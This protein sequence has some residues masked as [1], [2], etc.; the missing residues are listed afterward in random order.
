MG[1]QPV[2]SA[3]RMQPHAAMLH[4]AAAMLHGVTAQSSKDWAVAPKMGATAQ[5]SEQA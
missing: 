1:L 4:G 2:R 5:S 3:N